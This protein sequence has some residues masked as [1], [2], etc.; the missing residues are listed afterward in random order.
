M[1]E[2]MQDIKQTQ[3][4]ISIKHKLYQVYK[5]EHNK[6]MQNIKHKWERDE[7]SQTRKIYFKIRAHLLYVPAFK[8]MKDFH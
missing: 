2:S 3:V 7:Q 4:S 6:N 1:N 8:T 5:D